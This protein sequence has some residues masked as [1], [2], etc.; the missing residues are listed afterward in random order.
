MTSHVSLRADRRHALALLLM[1]IFSFPLC[2]RAQTPPATG[3]WTAASVNDG[4]TLTYST[5]VMLLGKS[6]PVSV[7]FSAFPTVR[8][9]IHG[10]LGW[11]VT[12]RGTDELRGF[13]FNAFDGPDAI[14][15]NR[16]LMTVGLMS[17]GKA[18]LNTAFAVS[19][20]FTDT[21]DFTFGVMALSRL[22]SSTERRVLENLADHTTQSMTI[23][24]QDARDAKTRLELTVP[25][26]GQHA[27]MRKLLSVLK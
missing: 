8:K 17:A 22:K 25:L 15:G 21:N 1:S 11:D 26:A 5:R 19:G 20:S 3:T 7:R 14:S 23:S 9:D 16:K 24:I 6:T 13:D 10:T 2:G 18:T 12:V 4:H 27:A